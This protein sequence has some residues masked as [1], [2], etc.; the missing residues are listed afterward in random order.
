MINWVAVLRRMLQLYNVK[1]QQDLGMALGVPLNF[2]IGGTGLDSAIPW[3]I[4]E[5]VVSEKRISWDWLLTG[6]GERDI[7]RVSSDT[8]EVRKAAEAQAGVQ[9]VIPPRLETREL[10]RVLLNPSESQST[11]V[12]LQTAAESP[13]PLSSSDPASVPDI[14][15]D[16]ESYAQDFHLPSGA[17]PVVRRLESIKTRMEKEISRVEKLLEDRPQP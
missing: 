9:V 13:A 14:N 12:P 16:S 7:C 11:Y 3:P 15:G 8:A 6:R 4:L 17:E 10:A 1:N 2:S 5:L